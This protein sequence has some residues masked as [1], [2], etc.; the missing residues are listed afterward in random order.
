MLY[1]HAAIRYIVALSNEVVVLRIPKEPYTYVSTI[2]SCLRP[3][4]R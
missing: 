4:A 2:G 1:E 3:S